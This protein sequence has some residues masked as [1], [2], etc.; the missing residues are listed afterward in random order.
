MNE[1]FVGSYTVSEL[2]SCRH[3]TQCVCVC[4]RGI[5][6]GV[7]VG[8]SDSFSTLN[9]RRVRTII[10]KNNKER[11]RFLH[12]G[13]LCLELQPPASLH[14]KLLLLTIGSQ[15]RYYLFREV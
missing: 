3:W 7:D 15:L 1:C 8:A 5:Y 9:Q 4:D 2:Q 13:L 11:E 14:L 10:F 12:K 6:R